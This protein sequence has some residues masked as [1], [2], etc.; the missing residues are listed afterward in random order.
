MRAVE[1][2]VSRGWNR[3]RPYTNV[4]N[5]TAG[6]KAQITSTSQQVIT[7]ATYYLPTYPFVDHVPPSP[8][9]GVPTQQGYPTAGNMVLQRCPVLLFSACSVSHFRHA[10]S[11][12]FRLQI[13]FFKAP[14]PLSALVHVASRLASVYLKLR[15]AAL[16]QGRFRGKEVA[17]QEVSELARV[18]ISEG[19]VSCLRVL[20]EFCEQQVRFTPTV[21]VVVP[22][23][24]SRTRLPVPMLGNGEQGWPTYRFARR[25]LVRCVFLSM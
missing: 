4:E 5:V 9:P 20:T 11:T 22:I 13:S 24:Q 10:R 1:I 6:K 19:H 15:K 25:G 16:R 2:A 12:V 3:L 17:Q 8:P 18:A 7:S 14:P 23:T 21:V